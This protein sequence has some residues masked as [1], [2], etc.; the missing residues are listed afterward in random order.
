MP[1]LK[2][3][4]VFGLLGENFPTPTN[5]LD[6]NRPNPPASQLPRNPQNVPKA[7]LTCSREKTTKLET[8]HQWNQEYEK[9]VTNLYL[10]IGHNTGRRLK[11][12]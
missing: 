3:Y 4:R 9:I 10:F 11:L 2:V 5:T 8:Q 1:Y 6:M 12:H 7:Q